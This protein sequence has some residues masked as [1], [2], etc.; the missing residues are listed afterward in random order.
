MSESNKVT[1]KKSFIGKLAG[2][3]RKKRKD[4]D[5]ES[6]GQTSG[7]SGGDGHPKSP[8][9]DVYRKVNNADATSCPGTPNASSID[10]T[11]VSRA[12]N[13]GNGRSEGSPKTAGK[14]TR[15]QTVNMERNGHKGD[16]QTAG[17]SNSNEGKPGQN[18]FFN[19][20][21]LVDTLNKDVRI[22]KLKINNTDSKIVINQMNA[23][24]EKGKSTGNLSEEKISSEIMKRK[25]FNNEI[26][27]PARSN[28][29]VVVVRKDEN[30]EDKTPIVIPEF[31]QA[32]TK[33]VI[34]A[35]DA[36]I[37]DE[38]HEEVKRDHVELIR[39]ETVALIQ[40]EK[41]ERIPENDYFTIGKYASFFL[42]QIERQ[43]HDPY[44]VY[45]MVR[46]RDPEDSDDS[47]SEG[48]EF[49]NLIIIIIHNEV[50]PF[51]AECNA[52]LLALLLIIHV[53]HSQLLISDK[54]N[55]SVG[56]TFGLRLGN[57]F[58]QPRLLCVELKSIGSQRSRPILLD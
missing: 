18:N 2:I 47:D 6:Q 17:G 56:Q 30:G 13:N 25:W 4:S 27:V 11:H 50:T 35:T 34:A 1:R 19:E 39:D 29:V 28:E 43:Y 21:E 44:E 58:T 49:L 12:V 16:N 20:T 7:N 32:K 5:S 57:S 42:L 33:E 37:K 48:S 55:L 41:Q 54:K 40:V 46:Y 24:T 14:V 9:R 3:F 53:Q 45:S 8:K 36:I 23:N 26:V 22:P 51:S 31:A 10:P 38:R 52:A 15:N